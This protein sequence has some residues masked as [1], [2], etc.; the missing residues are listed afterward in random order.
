[1]SAIQIARALGASAV[2]A[3]DISRRKLDLAAHFGAIPVNAAIDDPVARLQELTRGRGVNV[4][5]ELIGL[6]L[7]MQQAVRSL[8]I[9]GRAALVGIMDKSFD[10]SP[11]PEIIN[12]EA[13]IVGVS[14]HLASEIPT[15][16]EFARRGQLDLSHAVTRTIPLEAGAVNETLDRLEKFGDDV[17]VVIKP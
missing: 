4:T 1:M 2:Y 15:L 14:D 13:E 5:L 7:T 6:P 12:K 10:V 9:H 3:V 8:A 11:Y 16:L 17:R